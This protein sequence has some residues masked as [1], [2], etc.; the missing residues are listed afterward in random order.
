MAFSRVPLS[1]LTIVIPKLEPSFAGLTT[2]VLSNAVI[3]FSPERCGVNFIS[4]L[5]TFTI[6]TKSGVG[7]NKSL[8]IFFD[9]ILFKEVLHER[10]SLPVYLIFFDSRIS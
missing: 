10:V 3:S 2:K 1:G 7:N 5:P 6:S 9:S 4:G 8:Q